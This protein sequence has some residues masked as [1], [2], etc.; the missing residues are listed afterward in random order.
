MTAAP[1]LQTPAAVSAFLN[2]LRAMHLQT[3]GRRSETACGR[4]TAELLWRM[5]ETWNDAEGFA[6][7]APVILDLGSGYSSLALRAWKFYREP[8]AEVWTTDTEWRW[9]GTTIFE[10]ECLGYSTEHCLHHAL[11]RQLTDARKRHRFDL[12]FVDLDRLAERVRQ[13]DLL[14]EC[15]KPGGRMVLDDWHNATY[16]QEMTAALAA[17]GF[18]V[19]EETDTKDEFGRFVAVA[20]SYGP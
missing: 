7:G 12:I 6:A 8:E 18:G 10:L 5:L 17:V 4:P 20:R 14:V 9:L 13:V 1:A 2:S 16:R 15:L 11:F 3:N 19:S